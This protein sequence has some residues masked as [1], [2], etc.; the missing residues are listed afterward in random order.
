M[1]FFYDKIVKMIK[2]TKGGGAMLRG[3]TVLLGVTGGIAAYKTANLASML[4]KQHADVHVIMTKNACEFITPITFETLTGN[5]CIID[6]FDRNFTFEVEHISLAKKADILVIAPMT[7]NVGAKLAYGI[8]DDMLTT[9]ALAC[10]CPKLAAPAM[11]TRMYENAVTQ[12]NLASL[13]RYGWTLIE[14]DSGHL[15]CGD[16]DKG[17]MACEQ[18]ILEYILKEIACP[19]DMA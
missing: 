13:A 17:K 14:P 2:I 15:A 7:A 3:K 12:D 5:K 6:T 11:N 4:K 18:T 19:K 16:S 10:A 8:A 9:T 1:S